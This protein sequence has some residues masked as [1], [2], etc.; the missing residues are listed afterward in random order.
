VHLFSQV[1]SATT[2]NEYRVYGFALLD[3]TADKQIPL[4]NIEADRRRVIWCLRLR[5][6]VLDGDV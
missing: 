2:I 1:A 5:Y 3:G 4:T 6:F